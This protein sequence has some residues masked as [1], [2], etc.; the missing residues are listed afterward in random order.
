MGTNQPT[1]QSI[2]RET[3]ARV[4]GPR[5]GAENTLPSFAD[6]ENERINTTDPPYAFVACT[7]TTVI[8]PL[9]QVPFF[10]IST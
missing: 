7:G 8:Y 2:P 3:E 4:K 5:C 10:Y 9:Q 6:V 1:I